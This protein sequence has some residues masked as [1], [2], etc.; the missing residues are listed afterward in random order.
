MK[1]PARQ[2]FPGCTGRGELRLSVCGHAVTVSSPGAGRGSGQGDD[3]GRGVG[4]PHGKPA[5]RVG[6]LHEF[7]V[8]AMNDGV[9]E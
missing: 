3:V 7:A 4:G 9:V 1:A 2:D 5:F 6:G 8:V